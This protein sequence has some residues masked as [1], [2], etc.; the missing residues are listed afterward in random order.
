[1]KKTKIEFNDTELFLV[2][3]AIDDKLEELD[4]KM[5]KYGNN[6]DTRRFDSCMRLM[7]KYYKLVWKIREEIR[8]NIENNVDND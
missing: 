1:M 2:K 7:S 3:L 4:T 8:K 6:G 5:I